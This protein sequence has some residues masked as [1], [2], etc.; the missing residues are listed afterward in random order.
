MK[1]ITQK[2]DF[3][4]KQKT[5]LNNNLIGLLDQTYPGINAMFTSTVR[6]DSSQNW[7]DFVTIFWHVESVT[8]LIEV[9]WL[10]LQDFILVLNN[11]EHMSR[12]VVETLNED[13][14]NLE[15]RCSWLWV[16]LWK[17]YLIMNLS[18]FLLRRNGMKENLFLFVLPL[19]RISFYI[20]TL[21]ESGNT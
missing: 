3:Y 15:K 12:K 9:V 8:S 5:A 19:V 18:I 21:H 16:F 6:E 7:V 2:Y 17:G 20:L 13:P 1:T 11:L 4:S 14:H 10:L